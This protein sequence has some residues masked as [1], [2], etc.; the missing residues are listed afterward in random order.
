[1]LRREVLRGALLLIPIALAA[2][3][4]AATSPSASG[5]TP[6]TVDGSTAGGGG[7]PGGGP[8][9]L[10]PGAGP[11]A[12]P[13]AAFTSDGASTPDATFTSDA[14]STSDGA[15]ATNTVPPDTGSGRVVA[16]LDDPASHVNTTI[17]TTNGGN[18]FPGADV[19]FGML[20]WSPDTSPDRPSGGGY[21]YKD[22]ALIGFSLTHIS[23]PG[24][25]GALGDV[26]ILP[27]T[28]PL[29]GGDLNAM[30]QP[31]SHT[32]EVATAGYYA[33]GLGNPAIRAELTATL[34]SAMGRFTFPATDA[35]DLLFKLEDSANGD[36]GAATA[37]IVGDREVTGSISSGGFCGTGRPYI[38]YFD[39]VFD[40]PFRASKIIAEAGKS[41]PGFVFVTFDATKSQ[42]LQAKVGISFVS[43]DNARA[44]WA[45][46][47]PPSQW[48]FDAVKA[49]AVATWNDTLGAI[50]IAGGTNAQQELFYTAL[51]HSLLH[52][53][54]ATDTNGQYTGFD[55]KLHTV[56]GGQK[57]QYVNYSGWDIYRSQAQLSA[58]VAPQA[59]SDSAQ[60]MLNDAA[61]NGGMLPKWSLEYGENGIMVG[62]P[63]DGIIAAYYAFGATHFDTATALSVMLHE[64]SVPNDIRPGLSYCESL[65]YVPDDAGWDQAGGM[66]LEYNEADFALAQF[67]AALGDQTD[68]AAMLRRAQHWQNMFDASVGMFIPKLKNG[69][70]A[71]GVGPT[72][73][74]G[75]TEGDASQYR[76]A[77]AF[78]RQAQLAAMGGPTVANP[79]LDAFFSKLDDY[80]GP[81]AFITNE[82]ELGSE[83]WNNQTGEPWKTQEIANR[84][85]TQLYHD[86]PNFLDN[87]DDLG[88]MSS[89]LAWG[90]LGVY[91]DYPGSAILVVN[92]PE[93]PDERLRLPSGNVLTIHADGASATS[94]Y[95]QSLSVDGTA[96]DRTWLDASVV[97]TGAELDF[98]MGASPNQSWGRDAADPLASAGL[99]FTSAFI[100]ATSNPLTIAPNA[101]ID[102][103]LVAQSARPDV[104]QDVS[105]TASAPQGLSLRATNG[106]VSL[107]PGA[108]ATFKVTVTASGPASGNALT[109]TAKSSLNIDPP[110]LV[111][112][113]VVHR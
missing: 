48:T 35:A 80:Q 84:I 49:A 94:P 100:Y 65:G 95:I 6:A 78:N 51:Y 75:L 34:H 25:S 66:S 93:F 17:G 68:A 96:S 99:E 29:P 22:S 113:V 81:S 7:A 106:T 1:M 3:T 37:A 86:A 36:Y 73:S 54:V 11:D 111:L 61:Q 43:V 67:A 12:A 110:A 71:V 41:T 69:V 45:A 88:A 30:T 58:L 102:V 59:M 2:C 31:F 91:P 24:C 72:S 74:H 9:A 64:A 57:E 101:S 85:R 76:W 109:V 28:G 53:N 98:T 89:A 44:N 27:L 47:N 39:V 90:M 5:G 8:D 63:S 15:S 112:P 19:P 77:L 105:W 103:T 79:A 50:Q 83:Y 32:S 18:M 108:R 26:P 14:A 10:A 52:P 40:Q 55:G 56:G 4:V 82:F 16:W 21:D 107:A 23:G 62:D 60:S 97:Q 46:E 70:F 20:Q 38:L 13:D 33:V 92:G 42:T 104:S 87:N